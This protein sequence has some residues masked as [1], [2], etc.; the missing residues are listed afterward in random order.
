MTLAERAQ[1]RQERW[2]GHIL[3]GIMLKA[4]SGFQNGSEQI[5]ATLAEFALHHGLA[6]LPVLH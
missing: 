5:P 4:L 1:E 3:I 6:G 2:P